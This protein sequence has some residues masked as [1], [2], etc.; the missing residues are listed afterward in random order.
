M[1][2]TSE[3]PPAELDDDDGPLW[4][5]SETVSRYIIERSRRCAHTEL[6]SPSGD[7]RLVAGKRYVEA[8]LGGS[9][10]HSYVDMAHTRRLELERKVST[11]V[12]QAAFSFTHQHYD[13]GYALVNYAP[14]IFEP[15]R[16]A[17]YMLGQRNDD[18]ET[19]E[20]HSH[21]IERAKQR[22]VLLAGVA[23]L[24]WSVENQAQDRQSALQ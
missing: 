2:T 19:I 13:R 21:G 10:Y 6:L 18:A 4:G 11:A 3:Q 14:L 5:S 9:A 17:A 1:S 23:T 12:T 22:H 8:Y 15:T 24:L 20:L 7:I 16:G